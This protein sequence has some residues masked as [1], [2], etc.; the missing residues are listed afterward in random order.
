MLGRLINFSTLLLLLSAC[1]PSGGL[2]VSE[3]AEPVGGNLF[4]ETSENGDQFLVLDGEI[5][6]QTSYV[7]LALVEQADVEGL[8]IAQSPGGDLL[9]SHQIGRAIKERGINTIVLVNCISACVDIFIAGNIRGMTD[10]AELGRHSATDR[11]FAY[12]ID[13]RYWGELGFAR[14]NEMA[15]QVPNDKLWIIS[16][17][18]AQE[19]RLAT[20][21]ISAEG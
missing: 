9:A 10:L 6:A 2:L 13:R 12:E 3:A 15:Y 11:D 8:V 4:V 7:F 14:V 5:T 17:K 1:A 18:R 20:N 16:A 19:L 21:I